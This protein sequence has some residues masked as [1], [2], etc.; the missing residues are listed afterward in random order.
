MLRV[1]STKLRVDQVESFQ[2]EAEAQGETKSGLLKRLVQEFLKS[3]DRVEELIPVSIHHQVAVLD[4]GHSEY[5]PH[6]PH[7]E[8]TK[9][10]TSTSGPDSDISSTCVDRPLNAASLSTSRKPASHNATIRYWL[11][12]N[13]GATCARS[14]VN[15]SRNYRPRSKTTGPGNRTRRLPLTEPQ[16]IYSNIYAKNGGPLMVYHPFHTGVYFRVYYFAFSLYFI[17]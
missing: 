10:L 7:Q 15:V 1:L 13:H 4:K 11:V 5:S 17:K 3:A 14:N 9:M 6:Y 2:K 16:R 12:D 8:Q